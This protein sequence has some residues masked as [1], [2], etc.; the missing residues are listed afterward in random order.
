[1]TR[2]PRFARPMVLLFA[3]AGLTLAYV[4]PARGQTASTGAV[5]G[6][7]SDPSGA[8][9]PGAQVTLTDLATGAVRTAAADA[10]GSYTFSL[11]PPGQYKLTFSWTGFKT[12][13]SPA[14]TVNVTETAVFNGKMEVGSSAQSVVVTAGAQLLQTQSTTLGT[15]VS[16]TTITDIPLTTRNYTQVLSLSS[17]VTADVT[18]ASAVGKNTQDV[19]VNGSSNVSNNFQMDGA[20]VNNMGTG[21][22]GNWLGYAGI[23]IP[24]PDAL[25]EFKIQTSLFDAGYG[26]GTGANVNVVTKSGTNEFHGDLWEFFRND[27]L[28]ANDFFLN[29]VGKPRPVLKQNQF[30][31]TLGGPV[32]R[33]K[34]FFFGS[35]EGT[36][37]V[38]GFGQSALSSVFLPPIT[39]DRSAATLGKQF[40]GQSGKFGGA[41]VACDGSNI[42]PVALK[43]LNFKLP[44][45]QFY[46]PTPQ[47]ILSSGTGFGVFSIPAH[48]REDQFMV[49]ADYRITPTETLS[50]RFFYARDPETIAFTVQ[51]MLPGSGENALFN[52]RNAV[53][54]LTSVLGP[55]L[56]NEAHMAYILTAGQT[57]SQTPISDAAAGITASD[58]NF[59]NEIPIG[60]IAGLLSYGGNFNDDFTTAINQDQ[61]ADQISWVHGRHTL[62]TGFEFTRIQ[63]NFF[64]P[65]PLRGAMTF[66]SFPD[67]LLGMSAAQNGSQFSNIFAVTAIQGE[68]DRGF[69]ISNYASF[70]QDD[71]NATPQLTLNLGMR[72]EING[73]VSDIRGR[74]A[75]FWPSLVTG[76][77]PPQGTLQGFTVPPNF[78]LPVPSGVVVRSS[79]TPARNGAPL[80]NFGPRVGLAWRPF[81]SNKF[82]VRSGYGVYYDRVQ[83]NA[84]L[85]LLL[86]EPFVG[87]RRNAGVVEAA[88]TFQVPFNPAAQSGFF[89][90]RTPTSVLA[91]ST[92]AENYDSPMFQ[93]WTLDAQTALTH[94][95]MLDVAYVGNHGTRLGTARALNEPLLAS[96]QNPV[97]GITT[98][99]VANA[100]LRVPFPGFAPTGIS[101]GE[102]YGFSMYNAL[103]ATLRKQV[104]RG[105]SFQFSY[106]YDNA[107]TDVTGV[108]FSNVFSGGSSNF[109]D[110][111]NRHLR[112]GPADYDR[113][114]RLIFYYSW[115]LPGLQQKTGFLPKL[116]NG[117]RFSG[118]TTF[119]SGLPLTVTDA[120]GGSIFGF[121]SPS[122]GQLCPGMTNASIATSGSV[123]NRIS[124]Y[125]NSAAFCA[126]PPIGN[127]TGYGDVARGVIHGPGQNNW[128]M[129]LSKDTQVGGLAENAYVEFRTEFF[130]TFNHPQ[131]DIPGLVVGTPS[132]GQIGNTS[133][134]PRLLQF[135]L[136]YVF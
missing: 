79:K 10:N 42:N 114:Q 37:Q 11:V 55:H 3:W 46:F 136:K 50:E 128:D 36:R 81:K 111:R 109:G 57:S 104:S 65:G 88:G 112:W 34:F 78:T 71:F 72:W 64:L 118:V 21:R 91:N 92:L 113:R 110:T 134:N 73:G 54:K 107:M 106:T 26:R 70:V 100:S 17:G 31:G 95:L 84:V 62:R 74:L 68:M 48:F 58:P 13:T 5:T 8:V 27:V 80:H 130:N 49:N 19:Y 18:N 67:F 20:D 44:T 121:A 97:N 98:N 115:D 125:F 43:V 32:V 53:L 69:R 60:N 51:N 63:D 119:Q 28:N 131:F 2:L 99:T 41:S 25:E 94:T 12:L 39:N 38:N 123:E 83:A 135:A 45:G 61:A 93:Q 4:S 35:Y 86:E 40:C 59:A 77:P 6:T 96:A 56:I 89:P 102:T 82:V 90:L 87:L 15:L 22:A 1:M 75:N 122:G 126:P 30:G 129:A 14:I 7:V 124:G 9:I 108:G 120:R 76:P 52:N 29:R 66:E 23:A 85:Q 47:T 133:V 132:F 105:L 101:E 127:G 103:Q 24:N 117:W 16:N 33:N 116:T